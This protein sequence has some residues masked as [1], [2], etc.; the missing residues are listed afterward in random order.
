M[1][2]GSGAVEFSC[3]E[4]GLQPGVYQ[5]DARVEE[6]GTKEILEWQH[7][8]A[9]IHVE[10]DKKVEGSFYMPHAWRQTSG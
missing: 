8:C 3:N 4:L 2:R 5:I 10:A 1:S 7:G 9:S 6:A